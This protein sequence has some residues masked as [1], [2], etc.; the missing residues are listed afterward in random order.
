M[1]CFDFP[2]LFLLCHCAFHDLI[3]VPSSYFLEAIG[4][5]EPVV[6][7]MID[8]TTSSNFPRFYFCVKGQQEQLTINYFSLDGLYEPSSHPFLEVK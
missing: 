4:V 3:G 6:Q 1:Y 5:P 7:A 2:P 8:L